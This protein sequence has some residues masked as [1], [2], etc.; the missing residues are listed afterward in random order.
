MTGAVNWRP[1]RPSC[2]PKG[3]GPASFF[4]DYAF[5]EGIAVAPKTGSSFLNELAD[6]RTRAD[7]QLAVLAKGTR[8]HPNYPFT[9]C[10]E[11]TTAHAE[12]F[13]AA[14]RE[15][16]VRRSEIVEALAKLHGTDPKALQAA[17]FDG[18]RK[19]SASSR[20]RSLSQLLTKQLNS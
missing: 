9:F 19:G 7:A 5:S 13:K 15:G 1:S 16:T 8:E 20:I 4:A 11:E 17:I 14:Y 12:S 18:R 6:R 3:E 10:S 2:G